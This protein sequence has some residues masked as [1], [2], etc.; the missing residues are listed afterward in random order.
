MKKTKRTF[1]QK[2]N[3]VKLC[4][5]VFEHFYFLFYFQFLAQFYETPLFGWL[6]VLF[7]KV[8]RAEFPTAI[9]LRIR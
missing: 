7:S 1:L 2:A 8:L 3:F 6:L 9:R 4:R 5:V